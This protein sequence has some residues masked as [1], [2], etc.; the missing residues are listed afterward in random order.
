[1]LTHDRD[2]AARLGVATQAIDDVLYDAFGQR[3][4]ATLFTQTNQYKVILEVDPRFQLTTE[5]LRRL[6][7]RSSTTNELVPLDSRLLQ[8]RRPFAVLSHPARAARRSAVR[9]AGR[10]LFR[11]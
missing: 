4:V 10:H 3:Q 5:S 1:M 7:V 11:F 2:T 6:F 8:A 9:A